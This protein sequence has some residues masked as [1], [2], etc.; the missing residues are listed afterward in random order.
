MRVINIKSI[1]AVLILTLLVSG[2]A[3]N[4][5]EPS[6]ISYWPE[7]EVNGDELVILEQGV[8]TY[9]ELGATATVKGE[10]IPY[11]TEGTVDDSELGI[12]TVTYSAAN[13]DGVSASKTRTVLVV[14]PDALND[15]LEG[16]YQRGT[17]EPMSVWV[18]DADNPYMYHANNPGGV[19]GNPPFDVP[20]IIYNVAPGLV[21]VPLQE[22][23][24]L[25]PFSAQ[26]DFPGG[27]NL[28]PFNTA[29]AVGEV[30]YAWYMNGPNFGP[31]VRTFV[32]R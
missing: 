18:R 2:C 14:D 20:F 12:Y 24:P 29:A 11:K 30:A 6:K 9:T 7:L 4:Y 5:N 8:D 22:S 10:A 28:I 1:F 26:A 13:E 25:A 31:A 3:K 16:T 15:N 27:E 17:F 19:G 32:K 23:P 21:V